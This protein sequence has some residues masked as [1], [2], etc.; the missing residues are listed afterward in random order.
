MARWSKAKAG[1]ETKLPPLTTE[2]P[3]HGP[4]WHKVAKTENP[5]PAPLWTVIWDT[6]RHP[7][8]F[9]QA[10][11][12]TEAAAIDCARQFLRLGFIVY[13]IKDASG[14][15]TMNEATINRHLAPTPQPERPVRF[16]R[17]ALL[18]ED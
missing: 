16:A 2:Q 11:H 5:E 13:S 3:F 14:I 17:R 18:S 10:H 6:S 9:N 4:N 1:L 8:G 15:E 7:N 12:M